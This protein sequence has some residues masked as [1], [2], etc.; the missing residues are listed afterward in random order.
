MEYDNLKFFFVLAVSKCL[1]RSTFNRR[2]WFD[3]QDQPGG[4]RLAEFML[5]IRRV[6]RESRQMI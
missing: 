5:K 4:A 3:L 2:R 6:E 1:F